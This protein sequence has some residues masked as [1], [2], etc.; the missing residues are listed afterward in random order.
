[1]NTGDLMA[2]LV[3][4]NVG[5]IA[6]DGLA[7]PL[8]RRYAQMALKR[9]GFEVPEHDERTLR[10]LHALRQALEPRVTAVRQ[11]MGEAQPHPAAI[12]DGSAD[13]P[14][15]VDAWWVEHVLHPWSDRL[16]RALHDAETALFGAAE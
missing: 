5:W 6:S 3:G 15:W 7:S 2:E 1:L 4:P 10:D 9:P 14:S 8:V 12:L 16:F 11:R 13:F